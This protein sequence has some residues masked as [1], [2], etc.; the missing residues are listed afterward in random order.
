MG[1]YS[2][3]LIPGYLDLSHGHRLLHSMALRGQDQVSQEN[4]ID[5]VQLFTTS[6]QKSYIIFIVVTILHRFKVSESRY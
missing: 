4:Q 3:G 6:P 1:M 2:L 5:V